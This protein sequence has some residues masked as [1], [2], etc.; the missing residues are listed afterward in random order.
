MSQNAAKK[1]IE[2]FAPAD[3]HDWRKWLKEN[4]DKRQSVWLI[5]YKKSASITTIDWSGAVDEALCFGWIDSTRK[6]IDEERF[7]QFF[8]R[9]KPGSTWSKVNKAKIERLIAEGLMADAGLQCIETAKKDGSWTIADEVEELIIPPD[10]EQEFES[11]PGA[12]DFFLTISRSSRK[13]ILHWLASAKQ[14]KTR[15]TRI[16]QI[17]QHA[18]EKQKP[19]QFR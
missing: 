17:A 3:Q 11:R 2:T 9:R 5:Y 1:D 19:P 6:N 16:T 12:K 8:C 4:H 18:A 10:L 14:P 7:M 15:Q 13:M